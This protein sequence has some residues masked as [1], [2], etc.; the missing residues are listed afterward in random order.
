MW[1]EFLPPSF[2][3]WR[4]IPPVVANE[5][6]KCS[7]N[8]V[9]NVPIRSVGMSQ[10]KLRCG[11]PERSCR[12]ECLV[13][14]FMWSQYEL[15]VLNMSTLTGLYSQMK[16]IAC[17]L[18]KARCDILAYKTGWTHTREMDNAAGWLVA[19]QLTSHWKATLFIATW[20]TAWRLIKRHSF[21]SFDV[22][23]MWEFHLWEAIY[24]SLWIL[25]AIKEYDV[26]TLMNYILPTHSS[27]PWCICTGTMFLSQSLQENSSAQKTRMRYH[28]IVERRIWAP[29]TSK[30]CADAWLTIKSMRLIYL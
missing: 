2:L 12:E 22:S 27:V 25:G 3:M 17:F 10:S 15:Q 5:L 11:R 1:C 9:S 24:A 29:R 13:T 16:R 8:W 20:A 7:T 21:A 18:V 19:F 6:K 14:A 26:D 28:H 30:S 4:V 23:I